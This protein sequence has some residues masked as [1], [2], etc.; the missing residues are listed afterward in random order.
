MFSRLEIIKMLVASSGGAA[1]D[2]AGGA[3]EY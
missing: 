2:V 3:A 1:G